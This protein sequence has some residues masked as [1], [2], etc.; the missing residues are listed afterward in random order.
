MQ[1]VSATKYLITICSRFTKSY[2]KYVHFNTENQII[3]TNK[4]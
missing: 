4:Y 1:Y 3:L 2:D